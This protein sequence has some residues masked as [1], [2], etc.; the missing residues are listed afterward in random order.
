[1]RGTHDGLRAVCG[2]DVRRLDRLAALEH[3]NQRA[4]RVVH[5]RDA[6]LAMDGP[7]Q[8][9]EP[10]HEDGLDIALRYEQRVGVLRV[11]RERSEQV[12]VH[13][14]VLGVVDRRELAHVDPAAH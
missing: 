7:S 6:L 12:H 8:F 9:F 11:R 3:D 5:P 2:D 13:D 14:G 10:L 1:M 4:V